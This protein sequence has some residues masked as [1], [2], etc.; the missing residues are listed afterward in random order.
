[1]D[2]AKRRDVLVVVGFGAAFLVALFLEL[3]GINGTSYWQWPWRSLDLAHT[4]AVFA[5]PLLMLGLLAWLW[6]RSAL[7]SAADARALAY[8]LVACQLLLQWARLRAEPGGW[9]WLEAVVQSRTATSSF[10]DALRIGD[11]EAF[12]RDSASR[13][14]EPNSST[15]PPGTVLFYWLLLKIAPTPGLAARIGGALIAIVT[16]F[17]VVVAFHFASLWTSEPARRLGASFAYA[18]MPALLVALPSFEQLYPIFTML[19]LIVWHR[20][21]DR[22]SAAIWLGLLAFVATM[23]AY[24]FALLAVPFGLYA[25]CVLRSR[26]WDFEVRRAI[27]LAA[28]I[29]FGAWLCAYCML[30]VATGFHPIDRF[31]AALHPR[32]IAAHLVPRPYGMSILYDLFDFALGGGILMLPLLAIHFA[33]DDARETLITFACLVSLAMIDLTGIIRCEAARVWL[34]LQP[35]A[36]VP[37]GLALS[38]FKPAARGLVLGLSALILVAIVCK[39][40]FLRVP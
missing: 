4:L 38:R 39:L 9:A 15:Y 5:G 12:L 14:L 26:G 2:Q 3:P 30:A 29:A 27:L 8:G 36:I 24:Q 16:S 1:V 6:L 22:P 32:S 13:S 23:M 37:A 40:S 35:L 31:I 21:I 10:T 17:G 19:G 34:F 20:A 28:A 18:L 11:V 7:L 33:R 25:L